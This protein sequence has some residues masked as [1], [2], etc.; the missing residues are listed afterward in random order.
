[1]KVEELNDAL[2]QRFE[3]EAL[4]KEQESQSEAHVTEDCLTL[5]R[6]FSEVASRERTSAEHIKRSKRNNQTRPR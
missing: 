1:M 3:I 4:L 5:V 2:K 6:D